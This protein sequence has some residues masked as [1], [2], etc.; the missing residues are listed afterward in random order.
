MASLAAIR[1]RLAVDITDA[2][3]PTW[4]VSAYP[5]SAPDTPFIEVGQFGIQKHVAMNDGAEWWTCAIRA[6]VSQ[7]GKGN[8]MKADELLENDPVTDG[9][10]A[11]YNLNGLVSDLI[12]DRVDTGF[13]SRQDGQVIYVGVEWQLRILI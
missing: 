2:L 8:Q 6:Y 5:L 3:G 4:N 7:V 12:V 10:E 11:D 13:W 9:I 1:A